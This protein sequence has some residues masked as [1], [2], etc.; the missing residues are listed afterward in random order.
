MAS[1][2]G[3]AM[4]VA[5]QRRAV[6]QRSVVARGLPGQVGRKRRDDNVECRVTF[7]GDR[8]AAAV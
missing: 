5:R 6:M 7:G 1:E 4:L 8:P 3:D 2:T